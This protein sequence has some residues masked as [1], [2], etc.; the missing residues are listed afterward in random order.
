MPDLENCKLEELEVAAKASKIQ[1]NHMRL[2]ANMA[3]S[4]GLTH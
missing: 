3:L 2:M 1:R 4:M